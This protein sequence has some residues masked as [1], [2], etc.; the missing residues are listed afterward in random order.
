MRLLLA[1][2]S[3]L[4]GARPKA[5][6]IDKEGNLCIAKFPR[7]DDTFQ[8]VQWEAVALTLAKKAGL[9]VPAW[10]LEKVGDSSILIIQKFD[11]NG[12]IRIPFLSAMSMIGATDGL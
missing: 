7:K 8:N 12:D 1:P 5:T 6:V 3:S 9:N 11:R 4:G 10:F 2:G